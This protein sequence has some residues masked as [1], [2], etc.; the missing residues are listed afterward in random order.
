M[1]NFG[2]LAAEIFSLVLGTPANFSGFHVLAVL[3]HCTIVVGVSQTAALNRGHHLYSTGRPSRWALAHIS[4]CFCVNIVK[5]WQTDASLVQLY[6]SNVFV[7]RC[8][9]T[10]PCRCALSGQSNV[11]FSAILALILYWWVSIEVTNASK[12]SFFWISTSKN[13]LKCS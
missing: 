9:S 5:W 10:E 8:Q 6:N 2:A 4:S 12:Q 13:D 11:K 1:V 7:E 3:L